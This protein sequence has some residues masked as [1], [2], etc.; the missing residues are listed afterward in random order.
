MYKLLTLPQSS[1][2]NQEQLREL[3]RRNR[4]TFWAFRI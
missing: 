2:D 1:H 3:K 4:R